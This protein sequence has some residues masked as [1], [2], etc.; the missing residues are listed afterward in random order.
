M[1]ADD[2]GKT[3]EEQ[4]NLTTNNIVSCWE[5]ILSSLRISSYKMSLMD[6]IPYEWWKLCDNFKN[7]K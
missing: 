6:T 2:T 7:K 4:M 3:V 5:R 1:I